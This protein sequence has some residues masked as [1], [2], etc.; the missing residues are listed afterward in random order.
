[1]GSSAFHVA[2]RFARQGRSCPARHGALQTGSAHRHE[3]VRRRGRA[4]VQPFSA[5]RQRVGVPSQ[6]RSQGDP[7]RSKLSIGRS[8][9]KLN[10]P[11]GVK[12]RWPAAGVGDPQLADVNRLAASLAR[13]HR[14]PT[15]RSIAAAVQELGE[16]VGRDGRA[17]DGRLGTGAHSRRCRRPE[18]LWR[19]PAPKCGGRS[20][21]RP[22]SGCL[23]DP[24]DDVWIGR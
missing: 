18:G 3:G 5:Q 12:L 8:T 1:M 4:S 21:L 22:V 11:A 6:D 19:G 2:A 13:M 20:V 7:C 23:A 9:G 16:C 14:Q 10:G 24:D 17:C 15:P